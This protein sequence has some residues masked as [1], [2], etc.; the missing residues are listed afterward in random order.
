MRTLV[1]LT[2]LLLFGTLAAMPPTASAVGTCSNLT[3]ARCPHTFCY[4]YSWSYPDPYYKCHRYVDLPAPAPCRIC[5]G[6][7]VALLP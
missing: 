5:D 7:G 6:T 4:G 3:D 1:V 2:T